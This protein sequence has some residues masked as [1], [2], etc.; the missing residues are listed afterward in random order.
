MKHTR[1][2]VRVVVVNGDSANRPGP[3]HT[4][5]ILEKAAT[6]ADV[7]LGC[8]FFNIDAQR[9][10]GGA[11]ATRQA[12]E[13]GHADAS[14]VVAVRRA[15]GRVTRRRLRFGAGSM[16]AWGVRR[17]SWLTVWISVD[18]RRPVKYTAGHAPP[19]RAWIRWPVY[20]AT[21][22]GGVVGADFNKWKRAVKPRFPLRTVRQLP[23]QLIGLVV[24]RHIKSTKAKPLN[25]GGDHRAIQVTLYPNAGRQK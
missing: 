16:L 24:A 25:V 20:M 13:L 14:Y 6:S 18:G 19:K 23:R 8:E 4:R 17:R 5:R 3:A 9:V 12:G 10:L 22:P 2:P 7:I 21:A 1:R 15:R 11:W